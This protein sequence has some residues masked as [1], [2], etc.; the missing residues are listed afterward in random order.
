MW[1]VI[2]LTALIGA[3]HAPVERYREQVIYIRPVP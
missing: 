2:G 1:K 3:A